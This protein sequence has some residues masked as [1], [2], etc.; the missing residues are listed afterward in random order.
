MSPQVMLLTLIHHTQ[1]PE[2]RLSSQHVTEYISTL[3]NSMTSVSGKFYLVGN[4]GLSSSW[5]N[6]QMKEKN[7]FDYRWIWQW[8]C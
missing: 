6:K 8:K 7:T 3:L 2:S 1:E 5:I 4:E